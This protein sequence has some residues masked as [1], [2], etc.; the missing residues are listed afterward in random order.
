[1]IPQ[2]VPK[3]EPPRY[4]DLDEVL[5]GRC[6][7]CKTTVSCLRRDAVPGSKQ[8]ELGTWADLLSAE[9]PNCQA[10]VFVM[11]AAEFAKV[12][13]PKTVPAPVENG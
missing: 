11:N 6:M 10:R 7:T 9:C 4:A 1:M 12:V 13:G 8:P 5:A 2:L 3:P